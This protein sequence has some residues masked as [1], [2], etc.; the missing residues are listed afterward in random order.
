MARRLAFSLGC[1]QRDVAA[2]D[3]AAVAAAGMATS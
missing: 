2:L 1:P 3:T